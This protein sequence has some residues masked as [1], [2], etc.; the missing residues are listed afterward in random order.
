MKIAAAAVHSSASFQLKRCSFA[1][2]GT[3]MCLYHGNIH[4]H[5][6]AHFRPRPSSLRMPRPCSGSNDP[7]VLQTASDHISGFYPAQM[8]G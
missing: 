6:L 1:K 5:I 8:R 3:D 2:H 4:Q 7:E